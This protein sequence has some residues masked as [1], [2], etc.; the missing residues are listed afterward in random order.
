MNGINVTL[1]ITSFLLGTLGAAFVLRWGEK[2]SLI[3]IP[4]AR[5][6][7]FKATPKGGGIG[8]LF[9]FLLVSVAT[10]LSWMIYL[11]VFVL[12][13][14]NLFGDRKEISPLL[15]L[16][17]QFAVAAIVLSAVCS[18]DVFMAVFDF[19]NSP[20]VA[21]FLVYTVL[22]VFL[23]GTANC[24]NFMDG[25]NGIAGVTAIVAFSFLG[26]VAYERM[27]TNISV[28]S[29]CLTLASV[30][31]LPWNFPKAK[32]FMGDI[33]SILL[34]LMFGVV[35]VQL[36]Q[37]MTDLLCFAGF[38][39]PFYMDEFFTMIE[40]IKD[41]ESLSKPHR[42][43][44]YQVLA[45]EGGN[46][47]WKISLCYGAAQLIISVLML[48]FRSQGIVPLLIVYFISIICFASYNKYRKSKL[49]YN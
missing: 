17:L 3:D 21:R 42:R 33:G 32:V 18:Q 25:I 23:V 5:S 14:M 45:N 48:S 31:F 16:I 10:K 8:I 47:H 29:F 49:I 44:L 40:R 26:Y 20:L 13:L 43:H 35:S 46:S 28:M 19:F 30:G 22:A 1:L 39:L 24:F 27:Q 2:L 34:G 4:N 38:L 11:P 12:S 6:S 37:S 36:S 41:G 15:R 9:S 7:H